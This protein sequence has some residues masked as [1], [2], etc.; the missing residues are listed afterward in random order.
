MNGHWIRVPIA[1][2]HADDLHFFRRWLIPLDQY[3]Q[4]IL[5]C[6]NAKSSVNCYLSQRV[7]LK[8]AKITGLFKGIHS[9]QDLCRWLLKHED[10]TRH[11]KMLSRKYWVKKTRKVKDEAVRLD[12]TVEVLAVICGSIVPCK[13]HNFRRRYAYRECT[14]DG[15]ST[16][17]LVPLAEKLLTHDAEKDALANEPP[18][19]CKDHSGSSIRNSLKI[20]KLDGR[21]S[22]L[23][24]MP[25]VT[26]FL[27]YTPA[28]RRI[29]WSTRQTKYLALSSFLPSHPIIHADI[30]PANTSLRIDVQHTTGVTAIGRYGGPKPP[31]QATKSHPNIAWGHTTF[32][33]TTLQSP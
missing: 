28:S 32:P 30:G 21:S 11:A 18:T 1:L 33:A 7:I 6:W 8:A 24:V 2:C 13:G 16:L 19:L 3:I 27:M 22:G 5:D 31:T 29:R 17:D 15:A 23:H 10:G 9:L 26:A 20:L 4:D 12:P 14:N 25:K